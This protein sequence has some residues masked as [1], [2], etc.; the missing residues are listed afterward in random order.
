MGVREN[1][2]NGISVIYTDKTG[3]SLAEGKEEFSR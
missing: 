3:K 1:L 2:I